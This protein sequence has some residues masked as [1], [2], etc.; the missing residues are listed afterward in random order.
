M[1]Q[2]TARNRVVDLV[3]TASLAT[4]VSK[5]VDVPPQAIWANE[6]LVD[7]SVGWRP[8]GDFCSPTQGDAVEPKFVIN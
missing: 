3:T 4:H 6:L 7:K 5:S 8:F 1:H 2:A